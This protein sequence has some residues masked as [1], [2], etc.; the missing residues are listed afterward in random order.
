MDEKDLN[1]LADNAEETP[2]EP[3]TAEDSS[4]AE[5]VKKESEYEKFIKAQQIL[6][7][8]GDDEEDE[9]E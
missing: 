4:E 6:A 3:D 8:D 1:P 7:D 5:T 2:G 9:D